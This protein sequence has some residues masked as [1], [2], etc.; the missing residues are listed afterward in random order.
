MSE[1]K[2]RICFLDVLSF[3]FYKHEGR[4]ILRS[5]NTKFRE[6]Y[7]ITLESNLNG[8]LDYL[9]IKKTLKINRAFNV[10]LFDSWVLILDQLIQIKD[11]AALELFCHQVATEKYPSH[12]IKIDEIV[13]GEG[14]EPS[15]WNANK[16]IEETQQMLSYL[17]KVKEITKVAMHFI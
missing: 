5:L 11:V 14:Y 13:I 6:T 12:L 4:C 8:H 10:R 15:F 3:A 2:H 7:S 17:E 9:F 1:L 16:S